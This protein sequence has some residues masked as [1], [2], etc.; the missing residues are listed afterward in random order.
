MHLSECAFSSI[1][2]RRTDQPMQGLRNSSLALHPHRF[3]ELEI[4]LKRNVIK[5]NDSGQ[6]GNGIAPA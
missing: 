2:L 1:V 6:D 5:K 3:S 4:S